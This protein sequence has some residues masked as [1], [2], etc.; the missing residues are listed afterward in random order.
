MPTA[1]DCILGTKEH[2]FVHVISPGGNMVQTCIGCKLDP[3]QVA[4]MN[5]ATAMALTIEAVILLLN[6]NP[7]YEL[8]KHRLFNA[9][10]NAGLVPDRSKEADDDDGS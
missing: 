1:P 6:D 3:K 5:Q 8:M 7:D 2:H 10:K 9:A 4:A